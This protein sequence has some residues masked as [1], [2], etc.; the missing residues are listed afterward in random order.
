MVKVKI[1]YIFKNNFIQLNR[2]INCFNNRISRIVINF[3]LIRICNKKQ[4][5]VNNNKNNK[6]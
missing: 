2:I 6:L 3:K 5:K 4:N 1:D